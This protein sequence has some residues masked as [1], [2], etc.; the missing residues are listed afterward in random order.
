MKIVVGIPAR[1]GSS[2]FPGK[3]LCKILDMPMIEHVYKRCALANG[4]QDIFVAACDL[5]VKQVVEGFG[6]KVVMTKPDI[7]RPGLRVAEA[8]KQMNLSDD[9]IVVVAQ[10]DE[11]LVH[12][13]MISKAVEPLLEDPNIQVG[14]LV[15]EANEEEW[16]D[17]NEV[18]VIANIN[19]EILL[20]TRSPVPSNSRGRNGL[21]QMA[22]DFIQRYHVSQNNKFFEITV[23]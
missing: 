6:G 15:A 14:T 13:D 19:D 17:P 12:P 8:C 16:L 3:P 4:V 2:R 9:D 11:P 21:R 1:L 5:E 10:G 22:A 20:M 18:K 7:D 23:D